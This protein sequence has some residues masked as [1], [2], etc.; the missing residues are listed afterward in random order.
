MYE[1]LQ[2]PRKALEGPIRPNQAL[3]GPVRLIGSHK[4]LW[5][6]CKALKGAVRPCKADRAY[7]ALLPGEGRGNPYM[8]G[9]PGFMCLAMAPGFFRKFAYVGVLQAIEEAGL[10]HLHSVAGASAGAI[11]AGF[12]SGGEKPSV[13]ASMLFKLDR[14]EM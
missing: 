1:A 11:V 7:E 2:R 14:E 8:Q 12:L 6:P 5:R 9:L 13:L 10:L 4:A 3:C